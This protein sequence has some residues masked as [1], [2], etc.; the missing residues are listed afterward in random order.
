MNTPRIQL[1]YWLYN[2]TMAT[3]AWLYGFN[4]RFTTLG[5]FQWHWYDNAPQPAHKPVLLL[6]HGFSADKSLWLRFAR[7]MA[8]HYRILIPDLAGHGDTGYLPDQRYQVS[9]QGTLLLQWLDHLGIHQCTVAG[10]SMGGQISA[11]LV[12]HAPERFKA[13][14]LFD[15]SGLYGET[16]STRDQELTQGHNVF[17]MQTREDFARFY[18]LTMAKPPFMPAPVLDAIAHR[19]IQRRQSLAHIFSDFVASPPPGEA[20]TNAKVPVMLAW[21]AR[22]QLT[23]V[24]A[25]KRWQALRPN[26]PVVVWDDLGHMPML[27]APA[28]AAEASAQFLMKTT[29]LA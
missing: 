21:G 27:E 23:H 20:F 14:I 7:R 19:F 1:G 22:D 26:M 5:A 25:A 28:R 10:N 9:D 18:P 2:T 8:R 12:A 16:P 11:W 15:P 29:T 6:L 4:K 17:L 13:A 24:S 3:E